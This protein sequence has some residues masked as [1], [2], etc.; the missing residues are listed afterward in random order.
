MYRKF[1]GTSAA[2][3][4][5]SGVVALMMSE[6][7]TPCPSDKNLSPED[8]EYILQK[9]AKP[10]AASSD[11]VGSGRLDAGAALKAIEQPKYQIIHVNT[12]PI[13]TTINQTDTNNLVVLSSPYEH[14]FTPG[15]LGPYANVFGTTVTDGMY[16]VD[17]FKVTKK[18]DHSSYLSNFSS[19]MQVLDAWPLDS[20]S[21]GWAHH[22]S[23]HLTGPPF[24]WLLDTLDVTTTTAI[25]PGTFTANTIEI[26]SYAY[27]FKVKYDS[28]WIDLWYPTD[29]AHLHYAY[30]IYVYDKNATASSGPPHPCDTTLAIHENKP[31]PKPEMQITNVYPSP[32]NQTL[33]IEYG[34]E[35]KDNAS[36]SII[37][38]LGEKV[39]TQALANE[40]KGMHKTIIDVSNYT[41]GIYFV[42]L[43][44]N[45]KVSQKKFIVLK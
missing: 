12:S 24:P 45:T 29:T 40:K 16:Y 33:V 42:T 20:K 19:S 31:K 41:N 10:L 13:S 17:I 27:H 18:Y 44:S 11:S 32:T 28:T 4:H 26:S 39:Y 38:L 37:N 14:S 3:P 15:Y 2:A 34:L 5:V 25:E 9:T 35:E 43:T 22:S 1:N 7:N 23:M 6:V 36:I 30:S 8:V 21:E